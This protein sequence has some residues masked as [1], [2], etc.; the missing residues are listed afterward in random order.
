LLAIWHTFSVRPAPRLQP[1]PVS[2]RSH[3]FDRG[4]TLLQPVHHRYSAA[5]KYIQVL[6]LVPLYLY[7]FTVAISIRK[8]P[9][10]GRLYTLLILLKSMSLTASLP[11]STRSLSCLVAN[12]ATSCV[13]PAELFFRPTSIYKPIA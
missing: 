4:P 12:A 8:Q 11:I 1:R 10:I 2:L 13:N 5:S 6:V 3:R 7:T 9:R